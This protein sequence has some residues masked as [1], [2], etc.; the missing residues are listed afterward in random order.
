MP[1]VKVLILIGMMIALGVA[2]MARAETA[3]L[4]CDSPLELPDCIPTQD[5]TVAQDSRDCRVC[6]IKNPFSKKGC[7]QQ[8]NDPT[9]EMAKAA[10]NNAAAQSRAACEANK[11][12]QKV[13]CEAVRA[14]IAALNAKRT[15]GCKTIEPRPN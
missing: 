4:P 6:L 10:Q 11:A 7:L 1:A 14:S 2:D 9:C 15:A 5:C 12:A 8:A 13:Q 3:K